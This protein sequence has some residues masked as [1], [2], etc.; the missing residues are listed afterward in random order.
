MWS[1]L[2]K[3]TSPLATSKELLERTEKIF[4]KGWRPEVDT[5]DTFVDSSWYYFRFAD[6]H[7]DK[8]FASAARS[9][10]KMAPR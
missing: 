6:L 5:M 10:Q 3:G 4:G 2:P 8:A 9:A 1:Y 7:N